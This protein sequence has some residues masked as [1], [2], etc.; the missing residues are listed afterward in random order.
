MKI[1]Y[2]MDDFDEGDNIDLNL[3]N[4]W[5]EIEMYEYLSESFIEKYSTFLDWDRIATYQKL[6]EE[7]IE[8]HS[9]KFD[10]EM[11]SNWQ[12]LSEAFIKKHS[13]K[14][15]FITIINKPKPL[16]IFST[17]HEIIDDCPF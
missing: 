16:A 4:E 6:S 1:I 8:K 2:D 17:S 13:D 5:A 11:I 10:W 7:F 9:D 12:T 14:V 3:P 15:C